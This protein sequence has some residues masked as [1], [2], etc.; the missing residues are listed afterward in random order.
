MDFFEQVKQIKVAGGCICW[1]HLRAI[2]LTPPGTPEKETR[3]YFADYPK[4]DV[5]RNDNGRL[6]PNAKA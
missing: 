2:G 6:S 4:G 5:H 3:Q 1:D